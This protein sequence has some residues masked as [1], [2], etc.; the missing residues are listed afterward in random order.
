MNTLPWQR[1]YVDLPTDVGEAAAA[2]AK[3]QGITKKQFIANAITAA[4]KL[5][6]PTKEPKK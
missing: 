6:K 3:N 2:L 4:V 1:V 5:S